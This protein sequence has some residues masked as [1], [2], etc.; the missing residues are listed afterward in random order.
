MGD[1]NYRLECNT[2][3]PDLLKQLDE[4]PELVQQYDQLSRSISNHKAFQGYFEEKLN[5]PPTYKYKKG[6]NTL[7]LS[8][9]PAWCDRILI[10][11]NCSVKNY[12]SVPE[13]TCSDHKP[14][15]ADICL[16]AKK[17]RSLEMNAIADQIKNNLITDDSYPVELIIPEYVFFNSVRPS[18]VQKQDI[19]LT[20][21]GNGNAY[22]QFVFPNSSFWKDC[23]RIEPRCGV[24]RPHS[25]CVVSVQILLNPRIFRV[26]LDVYCKI[27]D[28]K[29]MGFNRR[30]VFFTCGE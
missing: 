21:E 16:L 2:P 17:Y 19:I 10:Q 26:G 24:I 27:V 9:E 15:V 20:N 29:G 18:E 25:S 3:L 7:N 12:S 6:G 22:F 4:Y 8:K 23:C 30:H 13:V 1:L 11:G 28:S 5:F 14:V